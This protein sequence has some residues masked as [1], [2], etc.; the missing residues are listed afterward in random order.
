MKGVCK[1]SKTELRKGKAG[2]E[3]TLSVAHSK[4]KK[5]LGLRQIK[6]MGI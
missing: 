2:L 6:Q 1:Y 4:K 3:R 5:M